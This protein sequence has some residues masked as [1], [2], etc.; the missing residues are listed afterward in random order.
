MW[1]PSRRLPRAGWTSLSSCS[2]TRTAGRLLRALSTPTT[3]CA[4]T[5]RLWAAA[6][7]STLSLPRRRARSNSR[8]SEPATTTTL[9]TPAAPR[10]LGGPT[11]ASLPTR[12][13]TSRG[14]L[15]AQTLLR[16][17]PGVVQATRTR[18]RACWRNSSLCLLPR[19]T[20]RT[21][22]TPQPRSAPTTGCGMSSDPPSVNVHPWLRTGEPPRAKKRATATHSAG[23][24]LASAKATLRAAPLLVDPQLLSRFFAV[25]CTRQTG[26]FGTILQLRSTSTPALCFRSKM[27]PRARDRST[28]TNGTGL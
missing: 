10:C 1:T 20:L 27:D 15:A 2:R 23:P 28:R 18:S 22:A 19:S 12:R 6:R 26:S 8:A 14:S 21:A 4:T 11:V 25:S 13:S 17:T 16:S 3:T 9:R 24:S 5:S 7:S